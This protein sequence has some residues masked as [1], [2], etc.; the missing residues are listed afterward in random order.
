MG[1]CCWHAKCW[2]GFHVEGASCTCAYVALLA[3]KAFRS[4]S[5]MHAQG[6]PW[7]LNMGSTL[8]KV[9][10]YMWEYAAV[11][12]NAG[13]CAVHAKSWSCTCECVAFF[14]T[15][16]CVCA[17]HAQGIPWNLS[18]GSTLNKV[19]KSMWEYEAVMHTNVIL[20]GFLCAGLI[21]QMWMWKY[22]YKCVCQTYIV[23]V[24]LLYVVLIHIYICWHQSMF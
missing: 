23:V 13:E 4:V 6:I 2:H 7:N 24:T 15:F 12:H 14:K 8:N 10:K 22:V 3:K 1:I 17:A 5:A 16:I 18:M 21:M 20:V 9:L 11:M 19:W